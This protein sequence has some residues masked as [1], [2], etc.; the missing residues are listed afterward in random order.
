MTLV[1]III[2]IT[3]VHAIFLLYPVYRDEALDV[4]SW[5]P[6]TEHEYVLYKKVT[7]NNNK[8]VKIRFLINWLIWPF[9]LLFI[10]VMPIVFLFRLPGIL[11]E[12]DG[13]IIYSKDGKKLLK[14]G[15][16]CRRAKVKKGVEIIAEGAFDSTRVRH[17]NL[18]NTIHTLEP[19]ALLRAHYLERINLPDSIIR[20]DRYAFQFCG[21]FDKGLKKIILPKHLHFLGENAFY[22]CSKLEQLT[23]RGDFMREL[24]WM[25]NNPFYY[26]EKLAVIKNSNP[27]FVVKDGMLMSADGKILFRCVNDNKRIVI[28]DGVETIA[29]GA[30][31][32]RDR[33]E[34]VILPNSLRK[35]CKDAF[36][37]CSSIDNVELPEGLLS[38]GVESFSFCWNL[39]T[40]TLPASLK[41]IAYSAFEHSD[42]LKNII[43]PKDKE[44]EFKKM[45]KDGMYDLSF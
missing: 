24:S 13:E 30:F 19:N 41:I 5:T 45:I 32:G 39:K 40:M 36:R 43:Y 44:G 9:L 7:G 15:E 31:C 18:P 4:Y 11:K 1:Y 6:W 42:H 33:M 38:I 26:T 12:Y 8:A 16:N 35:I 34:K 14:I 29:Q 17:I 28:N 25:D 27:N 10:L 22:G 23:I 21:G 20:I 3:I 2:V 37:G